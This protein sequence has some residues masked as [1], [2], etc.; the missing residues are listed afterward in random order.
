[1]RQGISVD[2]NQSPDRRERVAPKHTYP[3]YKY[4]AGLETIAGM[5]LVTEALVRRGYAAP[6]VEKIMGLNWLRVYRQV[7]GA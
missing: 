2:P 6:D 7:W 3:V 1:M 4:V 5:P